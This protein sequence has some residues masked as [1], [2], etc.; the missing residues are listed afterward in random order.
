MAAGSVDLTF[1]ELHA[2]DV[3]QIEDFLARLQPSER[4]FDD[5]ASETSSITE[6]DDIVDAEHYEHH[7]YDFRPARELGPSRTDAEPSHED[8]SFSIIPEAQ[9]RPGFYECVCT[10]TTTNRDD[11]FQL[12]CGCFRCAECLNTNVRVGLEDKK[13]WPP[14]CMDCEVDINHDHV[15]ASITE[16][17]QIRWLNVRE[18]Y[19]DPD[20]TYC[21]TPD[22][23][24][25][26]PR[27][28]FELE[29]KWAPCTICH[30]RTCTACKCLERAHD[31]DASRCPDSIE[32]AS[33]EEMHKRGYKPCP[34]CKQMID[35]IEGCDHMH[36]ERCGKNFCF[37]CGRKKGRSE[38]PCNC[39]GDHDWVDEGMED[40]DVDAQQDIL[41][42]IQ[43]GL[44]MPE[45]RRWDLHDLELLPH[46][47]FHGVGHRVGED[48]E[49]AEEDDVGQEMDGAQQP[50]DDVRALPADDGF[51][52]WRAQ[53]EIDRDRFFRGGGFRGQGHRLGEPDDDV[54]P[55][56]QQLAIPEPV[57]NGFNHWNAIDD[58]NDNQHFGGYHYAG[59]G[60]RLGDADVTVNIVQP[61][62]DPRQQAL[63]PQ[64]H[65]FGWTQAPDHDDNHDDMDADFYPSHRFR[66]EG[67]RIGDVVAQLPL[68]P[69]IEAP[70]QQDPRDRYFNHYDA[71]NA[72]AGNRPRYHPY[73]RRF[74]GHGNRLGD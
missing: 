9:A 49:L 29:G 31:H 62:N 38:L 59:P 5:E 6:S 71:V 11:F 57:N 54:L 32:A 1:V 33:L 16:D 25:Y 60:R 51:N 14:K 63:Q 22:C 70:Q 65:A 61:Q 10:E 41:D 34:W 24:T 21:A 18:E 36:C 4:E 23:P 68:E 58:F 17:L 7:G 37:N 15:S 53:A 19:N 35:R 26:L 45:G 46:G 47:R 64:V 27:A 66:G 48:D 52:H 39:R 30:T 42:R 50:P 67:R 12:A 3:H 40:M 73:G 2:Q 28:Q 72:D 74:A 56:P 69:A 13:S 20:P 44:A 55:D 8:R 43:N